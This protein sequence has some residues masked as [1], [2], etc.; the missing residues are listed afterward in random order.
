MAI[1]NWIGYAGAALGGPPEL[2]GGQMLY[3][4]NKQSMADQR[5]AAGTAAD[6]QRM[7]EEQDAA[8]QAARPKPLDYGKYGSIYSGA[9]YQLDPQLSGAT[10]FARQADVFRSEAPGVGYSSL[11]KEATRTGYSPWVDVQRESIG[12]DAAQQRQQLA[13]Q[14]ASQQATARSQ[15]AMGRGLS[16]GASERLARQGIQSGAM[17]QQQIGAGQARQMQDVYGQDIQAQRQALSQFAPMEQNRTQFGQNQ[18]FA[19]AGADS[20][21]RQNDLDRIFQERQAQRQFDLDQYK[22]QMGEWGAQG[23]ANAIRRYT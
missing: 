4:K 7:Q 8:Y 18:W 16:G 10:N 17:G 9:G 19:A 2:A 21:N 22:A 23:A 15:L 14:L 11:Q 12:M 5:N 6:I 1:Q 20:A 13:N 3:N